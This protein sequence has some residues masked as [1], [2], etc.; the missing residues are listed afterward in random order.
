MISWLLFHE[1]D[2]Y[3]RHRHQ[4]NRRRCC[5][6]HRRLYIRE[7]NVY[8]N[9]L[10]VTHCPLAK[11]LFS[12]T[13]LFI[14]RIQALLHS[15]VH[16]SSTRLPAL[17]N[18]FAYKKCCQ[19]PNYNALWPFD[20]CIP[21]ILWFLRR[22]ISFTE[23]IMLQSPAPYIWIGFWFTRWRMEREYH[24][25]R[26]AVRCWLLLCLRCGTM[27]GNLLSSL[28]WL[29][30]SWRLLVRRFFIR[31]LLLCRY[32]LDQHHIVR[33]LW[34]YRINTI[35]CWSHCGDYFKMS[36]LHTIGQLV[37]RWFHWGQE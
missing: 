26:Y 2:R 23:I 7:T 4:H 27:T 18:S 21:G 28:W 13:T 36:M 19:V 15:F 6:W 11:L 30:W 9:P 3:N 34:Q 29:Q 22:P 31:W 14:C 17:R 33:S 8:S 16:W 10:S 12:L 25:V 1:M 37:Q 24:C 20:K 5:Q 35:L 32:W